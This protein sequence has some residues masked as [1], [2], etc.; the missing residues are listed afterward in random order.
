MFTLFRSGQAGGGD[1]QHDPL[2]GF[3]FTDHSSFQERHGTEE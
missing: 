2:E 3:E 1:D